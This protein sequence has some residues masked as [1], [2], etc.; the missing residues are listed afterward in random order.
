MAFYMGYILGVYPI[1]FLAQKYRPGKV[2]AAIVL[3]WGL[4]EL[5][6]VASLNFCVGNPLTLDHSTVVCNSFSGYF[7]QRFFL[8]LLEVCIRS[9]F[10]LHS[11][12][13]ADELYSLALVLLSLSH[14]ANG[15]L[16][17]RVPFVLVSGSRHPTVP[18]L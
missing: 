16:R 2:C 7:A 14:P 8:G 15:T 11:S 5:L 4:V 18:P 1:T 13:F 3:I 6:W 17:L 9:F 12:S 10:N